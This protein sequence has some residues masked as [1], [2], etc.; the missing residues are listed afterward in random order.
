MAWTSKTTRSSAPPY[1][2]SQAYPIADLSVLASQL[3]LSGAIIGRVAGGLG[4]AAA[5][6]GK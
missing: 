5:S 1:P 2:S 6:I 3:L 4:M